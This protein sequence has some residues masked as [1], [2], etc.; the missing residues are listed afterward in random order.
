MATKQRRISEPGGR[1]P[2]KRDLLGAS[3]PIA[4][5]TRDSGPIFVVECEGGNGAVLDWHFN[6]WAKY[7]NWNHDDQLPEFVG[8]AA[9]LPR[10]QPK[11]GSHRVVLEGGSI[12]VNGA[13]TAA[14]DRGMPAQQD[15]G[16]QSAAR[17][18]R[19]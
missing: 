17:P 9:R 10:W 1:R 13:G 19:L 3:R 8:R 6:A 2:G 11:Y 16:A 4:S 18:R 14:D 7:D 5:W 12:D 15:A